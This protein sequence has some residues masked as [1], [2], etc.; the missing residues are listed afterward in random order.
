MTSSPVAIAE[1]TS[2]ARNKSS[3]TAG[4]MERRSIVTKATA[5][6][7]KTPNA[8][9]A[10]AEPM[11]SW[12]ASITAKVSEAIATIAAAWPGRSSGVSTRGERGPCAFASTA[13]IPTGTLMKK[14]ARQSTAPVSRP[15]TT[16]PAASAIPPTAAQIAIP[17][18]RSPGSS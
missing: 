11:P 3:G 5:A 10:G 1:P 14:I 17:F 15:P 7:A 18:A 12:P 9:S 6:I 4:W 2:G 16:G 13:T 8:S